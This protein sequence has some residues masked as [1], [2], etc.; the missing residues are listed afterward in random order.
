M[1]KLSRELERLAEIA[2]EGGL[3]GRSLKKNSLITPLDAVFT[4]LNLRSEAADIELLRAAAVEDIFEHLQRVADPNYPA[5]RK[6]LEAT[7]TFVDRFFER[8]F[9]GIYDGKLRKLLADEKLLRSAFLFYVRQQ[10]PS[11]KQEEEEEAA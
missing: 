11:G 10:I 4:K 3:R 9:E 8:I 6:K 2:W 7:Q 1:A 5:G